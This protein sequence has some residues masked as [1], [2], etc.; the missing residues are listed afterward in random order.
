MKKQVVWLMC[1]VLAGVCFAGVELNG[2]GAVVRDSIT[3]KGMFEVIEPAIWSAVGVLLLWAIGVALKKFKENE[4]LAQVYDAIRVGVDAAQEDYVVWHK[5]ASADGKL[6]AAERREAMDIAY[7]HAKALL[8]GPAALLLMSWGWS[9][10]QSVIKQQVEKKKQSGSKNILLEV[11]KNVESGV[12][13]GS[14][15][16]PAGTVTG[17]SGCNVQ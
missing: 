4:I 1:F 9:K 6:T 17:N 15:A 12:A 16:A 3:L 8:T 11:T 13:N 10:I 7:Q 2:G 14:I 5:R